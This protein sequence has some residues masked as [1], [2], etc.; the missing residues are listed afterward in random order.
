MKKR[1]LSH[2]CNVK[3]ILFPDTFWR[4]D[5][6][7]FQV[8]PVLCSSN[9]IYS[10]SS[11]KGGRLSVFTSCWHHHTAPVQSLLYLQ[12]TPESQQQ[13]QQQGHLSHVYVPK[14]THTLPYTHIYLNMKPYHPQQYQY[15][16]PS[17]PP[18]TARF[19]NNLVS[20]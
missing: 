5:G 19:F 6:P 17:A 1:V 20:Y 12:S 3:A 11:M 7:P 14:Y 10:G 9:S 13:Q 18:H 2:S 4:N 8:N 15:S 16:N